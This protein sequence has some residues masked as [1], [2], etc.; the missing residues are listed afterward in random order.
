MK[1]WPS[2][3]VYMSIK[4]TDNFYKFHGLIGRFNEYLSQIASGVGKTPY[5]LMSPIQFLPP[6]K[7]IYLTNT[8][9]LGSQSHWEKRL[10]MW[11]AIGWERCCA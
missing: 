11:R 6:L 4:V 3:F 1:F 7:E 10:I 8:I 2:A 5:D 9:C